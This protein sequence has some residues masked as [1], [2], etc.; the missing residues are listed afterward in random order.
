MISNLDG[1]DQWPVV[2][3]FRD[4]SCMPEIEK[5]ALVHCKGK[6]LDVGAGAGS[7]ALSLRSLGHEVATLDYSPGAA[8]V[9]KLRGLPEVYC[10][11]VWQHQSGPYDT[12]LL[13]MN[14]IG[15]AGDIEGYRSLLKRFSGWLNPGGRVIFDSADILDELPD[16]KGYKGIVEYRMRYKEEETPA[17]PWIY[18]DLVNAEQIAREEGFSFEILFRDYEF[19]YL[20]CL[21]K[22]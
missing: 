3:F 13:L 16:Q 10:E 1:L 6:V 18:L 2:L 15:L 14:G 7:H 9:M 4:L 12:I 5:R 19:S 22:V 17:F 8:E 21:E 11:S 20:A